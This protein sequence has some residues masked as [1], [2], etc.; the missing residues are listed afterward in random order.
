MKMENV[1]L[2]IG[3]MFI[4]D[5]IEYLVYRYIFFNIVFDCFWF[6]EIVLLIFG[7]ISVIVCIVFY[8]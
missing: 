4:R 7:N 1:I 3:D 2:G 6:K 5:C 8:L